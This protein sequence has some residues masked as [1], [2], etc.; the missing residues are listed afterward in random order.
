MNVKFPVST[1]Y[2]S[3][4]GHWNYMISW[5]SNMQQNIGD[6]PDVS[7]WKAYYQEPQFYQIWINSDTLPKRNQFTDIMVVNGYGFNGNRIQVD[8]LS[9]IRTFSNPAEPNILLNELIRHLYRINL[10]EASKAQIKRDILLSGQS[11]D[12]YW[13]DAWNLMISNPSNTANTTTVRNK[14]RD[15]IKYLMNLAEY[16]LA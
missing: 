15:L 11:S 4:Y 10:S 3:N 13:T 2:I 1:D 14:V 7:G 5:V 16:Q 9:L 12:H 6:P 8:G